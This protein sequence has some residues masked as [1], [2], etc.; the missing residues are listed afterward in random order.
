[1]GE[2]RYSSTILDLGTRWK[3]VV[4]FTLPPLYPRGKRPPYPLHRRL[5]GP[6]SQSRHCG[7]GKNLAPPGFEPVQP[8][9]IPTEPPQLPI[10]CNVLPPSSGSK[11]KPSK[12]P[13]ELAVSRDL[14]YILTLKMEAV[15]SFET[16]L[17]LYRYIRHEST[18]QKKLVIEFSSS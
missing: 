3:R 6:Q 18:L 2:W 16:S 10:R 14:T 5:G 11:S 17:A 12:K 15:C 7:Q 13:E 9:A 4:S 8:V 1:M